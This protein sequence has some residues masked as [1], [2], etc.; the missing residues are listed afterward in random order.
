MG[1]EN[2]AFLTTCW[3][4]IRKA[5]SEDEAG[6]KRI[7]DNFLG[8]YWKPVYCYL[9]H[10]GFDNETAKDL[11][12]GF[13]QEVVLGRDLIQK[14]DESK[15]R[16]RTFLLTALGNYVSNVHRKETTQKRQPKGRFIRFEDF[17]E[18]EK[19]MMPTASTPDEVFHYTWAC[20]LLDEVLGKVSEQCCDDGRKLYWQVFEL[21]ILKPILDDTEAPSLTEICTKYGIESTSKASNMIVT[22]KRRFGVVLKECLGRHVESES[23]VENEFN[24]L[25]KILSDT[26]A[27]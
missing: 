14:A 4:D 21:R 18:A 26:S 12:Q 6:R 11:T 15:G 8:M 17:G 7:I 1:G 10:K 23:E 27:S 13:F 19:S 16:F 3:I 20:N 22:V 24:E 2:E 25:L 9:R 5:K